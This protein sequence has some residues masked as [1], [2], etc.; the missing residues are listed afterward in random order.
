MVRLSHV[1]G[2]RFGEE[3]LEVAVRGSYLRDFGFENG[4]KVVIDVTRG[5]I[6]IRLIDEE[7]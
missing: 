1:D 5:Q 6:V 7:D 4:S 2:S 3:S